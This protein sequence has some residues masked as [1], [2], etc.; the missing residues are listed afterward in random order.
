MRYTKPELRELGSVQ[1]LT[2]V[3]G[4]DN[5]PGPGCQSE[6]QKCAGTGDGLSLEAGYS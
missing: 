6:N 2:L 5:D 4:G 1:A 3:P